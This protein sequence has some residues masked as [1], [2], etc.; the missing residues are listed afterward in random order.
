MA[1]CKRFGDQGMPS[2]LSPCPLR[3]RNNVDEVGTKTISVDEHDLWFRDLST[4]VGVPQNPVVDGVV[5]Q[6]CDDRTE[7]ALGAKGH[8]AMSFLRLVRRRHATD[9]KA[10]P[11]IPS[12]DDL[13]R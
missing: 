7:P 9:L 1:F 8:A 13:L 3:R 11:P 10:V 6:P 2:R 5:G 4:I 12:F